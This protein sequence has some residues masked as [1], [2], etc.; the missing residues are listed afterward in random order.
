ML[1]LLHPVRS[2]QTGH[3]TVLPIKVDVKNASAVPNW[4]GESNI[5]LHFKQ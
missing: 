5:A 1:S 3:F 2:L 4:I